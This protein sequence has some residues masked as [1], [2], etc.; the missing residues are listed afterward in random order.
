[1]VR[2]KL[3]LGKTHTCDQEDALKFGSSGI[4][5][6]MTTSS[7]EKS[8]CLRL[9]VDI[10]LCTLGWLFLCSL[11]AGGLHVNAGT[12]T[13]VGGVGDWNVGANWSTGSPPGPSDDVLIEKGTG[14]TVTHSSGIHVVRS[15]L[16]EQPFILSG[17]TLTVSNT[18]Q[19]DSQ[20]T[21]SGGT[22]SGATVVT[23]T[24]SSG[25]VVRGTAGILKGVRITGALD[26]GNAFQ[27]SALTIQGGL[28]I[29]GEALIGNPTNG[30]WGQIHF[31][32]AQALSGNA[33]IRFGNNPQLNQFRAIT[34]GSG[35]T[36]GAGITLEG[37][38]GALNGTGDFW[39]LNQGS[40]SLV[41]GASFLL[42]G[43][44][45]NSGII[46]SVNSTVNLGGTFTA[47][48]LGRFDRS[49][50]TVVLI[51]TLNNTNS[52]LDLD[53]LGGPWIL[54]GGV[55]NGGTVNGRELII[56]STGTLNS[57]V[58]SSDLD[59]GN[60]FGSATLFATHGLV[61]NGTAV[62]GN[63]TNQNWG[64]IDFVGS[65]ELSGD[66]TITF[67]NGPNGLYLSQANTTLTVGNEITIQG[68]TGTLGD[69]NGAQGGLIV[70]E[71][72][73]VLHEGGSIDLPSGWTNQGTISVSKADLYLGGIFDLATLGTL[74]GTGGFV[75]INGVLSNT[76][77]SLVA[78]SYGV[79]WVMDGGEIDGGTLDV[80]GGP[81][82]IVT[83]HGG[84]LNGVTVHGTID[85]GNTVAVAQTGP[86]LTI[87]NG[88][89]LDGTALIG[90]PTNGGAGIIVFQGTQ[91]LD[92]HAQ[93]VF[94]NSFENEVYNAIEL[95]QPG[96]TLVIGDQVRLSGQLGIL[97]GGGVS[98]HPL[99][100]SQKVAFLNRG[101]LSV[102]P[103][104][105]MGL[106]GTWTNLGVINVSEGTLVLGGVF[107]VQSLG[108]LHRSGGT[109]NLFGTLNNTNSVLP[110]DNLGGDWVLG[111]VING[112]SI[113]AT[114]NSALIVGP[115]LGRATL[116]GV[117]MIG[118]VDVGYTYSRPTLHVTNGLTLNGIML[119]GDPTPAN[120]Q[121]TPNEGI[122][123]FDGSQQISG[124]GRFV[125][126]YFGRDLKI[127][128]AGATVTLG[129][130]IS[131][132]GR[133][134]NLLSSF[135]DSFFVNYGT[136]SIDEIGGTVTV[137]AGCTNYGSLHIFSGAQLTWNENLNVD[138]IE[139]FVC[140]PGG[141][142]SIGG[143]LVGYTPIP[144]VYRPE[145]VF[146]F[147]PGQHVLTAMSQ[148]LGTVA[149]GYLNNYAYG[150]L[151]LETGTSV[152]LLD[153]Q[154]IVTGDRHHCLYVD[155]L[156]V[157]N[158]ALLDLNGLSVYARA[159]QVAPGSIIGG[160]VTLVPSSG[161]RLLSGQRVTSSLQPSG[162][163]VSWA[164]FARAGD[165][166]VLRLEMAGSALPSPPLNFATLQVT[167]PGGHLLALVTNATA[168]VGV[169]L[170]LPQLAVDGLYTVSVA[171]PEKPGA[172]LGYF[173]I[174]F[175]DNPTHSENL[176]PSQIMRGAIANAFE[177]DTWVFTAQANDVVRF[178]LLNRSASAVIFNLLGPAGWI[179]FTN[180]STDSDFLTLPTSGKYA[181]IA[182]SNHGEYGADYSFVL[183]DI[184]QT[185]L[186][187]NRS[188]DGEMTGDSE[189]LVYA[190]EL[191]E[192]TSIK[193]H[194]SLLG[195]IS[196]TTFEVYI[197]REAPPSRSSYDFRFTVQDSRDGDVVIS[198]AEP[199][200]WYILLYGSRI[201]VSTAFSLEALVKP[202][203]L[204]QVLSGVQSDAGDM[205]LE[206]LGGGFDHST[207]VTAVAGDGTSVYPSSI[208]LQSG[209]LLSAS[210]APNSLSRGVYTV[211]V[212]SEAGS[213]CLPNAITLTNIATPNFKV[214]ISSPRFISYHR[215]ATVYVDYWNLG[216]A[217]IQS[218]LVT[219]TATQLGLA[220]GFLTLK[221]SY[222]TNLHGAYWAFPEP[223]GFGTSVQF[224]AGG[225]IPGLLQ[226]N[227]HYTVPVYYYGW[228]GPWEEVDYPP[229]QFS[230]TTTFADNTV[231]IDWTSFA[232]S[233]RPDGLSQ[234]QWANLVGSLTNL[235][236]ET[237][238][239][240]VQILD[241]MMSLVTPVSG[242]AVDVEELFQAAYEQVSEVG[243]CSL[244]GSVTDATTGLAIPGAEIIVQQGLQGGQVI[245]RSTIAGGSG[246]FAFTNLPSGTYQAFVAGYAL[247][248]S[249][250][251]FLVNGGVSTRL[252]LSVSPTSGLMTTTN[253]PAQP[254]EADPRLAVDASGIPHL[255]WQRGG[256]IWHAYHDGTNWIATGN[257]PGVSGSGPIL[258]A[259]SNMIDGKLPGLLV[260]WRTIEANGSTLY[261]SVL[262]S[263]N[264]WLSLE[265]SLPQTLNTDPN[266]GVDNSGLAL[267]SL[268]TGAILA[269][270][271]KRASGYEDD[272]DIYSRSIVISGASLN[273]SPVL[274]SGGVLVNLDRAE[275]E[276]QNCVSIGWEMKNTLFG[277]VPIIAGDY[278]FSVKGEFCG[279][280]NDC[281]PS[282][283]LGAS[284]EVEIAD[285]KV[286]AEAKG[287]AS[288]K[289]DPVACEF[290]FQGAEASVGLSRT[291]PLKVKPIHLA[292]AEIEVRVE[293]TVG[294][295]I[296]AEWE[297][298][299]FTLYPAS[300]KGTC[301]AKLEIFGKAALSKYLEGKLS[302]SGSIQVIIEGDLA[303]SNKGQ[304]AIYDGPYELEVEF[305][306]V[307]GGFLNYSYSHKWSSPEVATRLNSFPHVSQDWTITIKP[308][309]GASNVF[310]DVPILKDVASNLVNDGEPAV[311]ALSSGDVLAAWTLDSENTTNWL[312]SRVLV[313]TM[314]GGAWGQP[315][316]LPQSRGFNS[317]V[318]SITD[319]SG[320]PMVVWAMSSSG[321]V[322]IDSP[323]ES[324]TNAMY[325]NDMVFSRFDGNQWTEPLVIP[326]PPGS[327]SGLS[328]G[329][330]VDN[331]IVAAWLNQS[332]DGTTIYS[333]VWDGSHWSAT[334]MVASGTIFGDVAS[335]VV[336][337]KTVLFWTEAGTNSLS[338]GDSLRIATST[339]DAATAKWSEPT[340]FAP[341][342]SGSSA[343][344]GKFLARAKETSYFDLGTP[345]SSCCNRTPPPPKKK[346]KPPTDQPDPSTS[347]SSPASNSSASAW[348]QPV[349][350][351][352]PNEK[353]GPSG[354]GPQNYVSVNSIL[355]FIIYF[356][357]S[358]NATAP[359][360][361]VS[362]S[363]RL[364]TNTLWS[365]FELGEIAF[366][367][368]TISIPAHSQ[369]YSTNLLM[370]YMG[371][372]F[373]VDVEAGIDLA[374]GKVFANFNSEDPMTSLPPP[375]TIGFLP[376]EDGTGRGQGHISYF[377]LPNPQLATDTVITNVAFIQFD[378]NSVIG[379]DQL[380]PEDP[381]KGIATNKVAMVTIDSLAPLS[382]VVALP[383]VEA[384]DSFEVCWS[385]TDVGS[386]I[387][388]YDI[389]VSANG[390]GWAPWITSTT[391]SCAV[392]TGQDGNTYSFR[393]VAR[394]LVGNVE[395]ASGAP[396]S[397][398]TLHLSQPLALNIS[399]VKP[400]GQQVGEVRLT[401]P[402]A[403][404]FDYAVEYR[405]DLGPQGSWQILPGAPH[406]SGEVTDTNLAQERFY[407][408][409]RT[410]IP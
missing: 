185:K 303:G 244:T 43:S 101:D 224:L 114:N 402:T 69:A 380:D 252:N 34:S 11:V 338:A 23:S 400:P 255:V 162:S 145:G 225:A 151:T 198:D 13:W 222:A 194:L 344:T 32:G 121:F 254:N 94:G 373:E 79:T 8:A 337:E 31:S 182:A 397:T 354:Y 294:G 200:T 390:D 312:G 128:T 310:E 55:I 191:N 57:V 261:Y 144:A 271:Q 14:I 1:M 270:W 165:S 113:T 286:A 377:V 388:T 168:Q 289:A 318:K 86:I 251:I 186:E 329:H 174:T 359:A 407:R 171:S 211:C 38:G 375:L 395:V 316:E 246:F 59:V 284:A 345:P 304:V 333:S 324:I 149:Q 394:D 161:E 53:K 72:H 90:N 315:V 111:G 39:Y 302:G 360:Q 142:V 396:Q 143:D 82:L 273:W 277:D 269:A 351:I 307:A 256:E 374:T 409:K 107:T 206:L 356:E 404:G 372:T 357:N 281:E 214:E 12:V 299:T 22:L 296:G 230:A 202:V 370:N 105:Q 99:N 61:L 339:L 80:S 70:N 21:L 228:Q 170:Q 342:S 218:P 279:P 44:W 264:G 275:L 309:I 265:S 177:S 93:V 166:L 35:L 178:R 18:I 150:T 384:N 176:T 365:S 192:K 349:G 68:G 259:S 2:I 181:L 250:R 146:T 207:T 122:V 29:D 115:I 77:S 33:I 320:V 123:E 160:N 159:A 234:D 326:A 78:N 325:F 368:Q 54:N 272:T 248:G 190:L 330:N 240:Y 385:G 193:C 376:P 237:W 229:I 137:T 292:G 201:P 138:L 41:D 15:I 231:P 112:G 366:G 253:S 184:T 306:F 290:L 5:P 83:T 199:G 335:G 358:T 179:G 64:K 213:D 98:Y 87:A 28:V 60:S 334:T 49:G 268:P 319:A 223:S 332:T 242:A 363:D 62:V 408:L 157:P 217:P 232:A 305:E 24:N 322:S 6:P 393:S 346:P 183:D 51:G 401:F 97:A 153:S 136:M 280:K 164:F 383:S 288:W 293:L 175:W 391:N 282:F 353:I 392:F 180:L 50:G 3:S 257:V 71:G 348:S 104:S 109:I 398:T 233:S 227:E 297:A 267:Q 219:V 266:A 134:G 147:T 46:R 4:T 379:T 125:F 126:G 102:G 63:P 367:E 88:L 410:P 91:T 10:A 262:Q 84:T 169:T 205:V 73:L 361:Q 187:P 386:G 274:S 300:I 341:L 65:Q 133:S 301:T 148:D 204:E 343:V 369:Y 116:N 245:M 17:G 278:G 56:K 308:L 130:D 387:G 95:S 81:G 132:E 311:A 243:I 405:D 127:G 42:S 389:Y 16:T 287:K 241:S 340:P 108:N 89:T 313:A 189:A 66:G 96:S 212:V 238:G 327:K 196:N 48:S 197:R 139:A 220:R 25:L 203:F 152:K 92:G 155:T 75:H 141:V 331:H 352:D 323:L 249:N 100:L 85:I 195:S 350:P 362:I 163:P 172:N 382:S 67:G 158:G 406:N 328:L 167:D 188:T 321:S 30:F 173:A 364:D 9:P 295:E 276:Q 260:A 74:Q 215:A 226:P 36:L 58:L 154:G 140:Q 336:A 347:D 355:P 117:T 47:N 131:I 45:T 378:E 247:T 317:S 216:T 40:I 124:A 129:P 258:V 403:S 314:Q 135:G 239:G 37:Q 210:F 221:Q 76:N 120:F 7:I 156:V 209:N 106:Y 371:T 235:F 26:V 118:T 285:E 103:G 283:E 263:T 208:I 19:V 27:S 110:L 119:V 298:G 236:G 381:A 399:L 291:V 52:I 20:F